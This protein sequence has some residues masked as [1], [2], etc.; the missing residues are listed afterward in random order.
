MDCGC[1]AGATD[2]IGPRSAGWP[3]PS[4]SRNRRGLAPGPPG[5]P[6]AP[7]SRHPGASSRGRNAVRCRPWG[8]RAGG[9]AGRGRRDLRGQEDDIDSLAVASR[10]RL[11][12][13]TDVE[14]LQVVPTVR[15]E[16]VNH[17][18][19]H[20]QALAGVLVQC[21]RPPATRRTLAPN[22]AASSRQGS[23]RASC[24]RPTS[25]RPTSR[26]RPRLLDKQIN[27]S[28]SLAVTQEPV[29]PPQHA[30][31]VGIAPIGAGLVGR[32]VDVRRLRGAC[33]FRA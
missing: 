12:V 10:A 21:I 26:D 8:G 3:A 22:R 33:S 4:P 30:E 1:P 31:K 27:K 17:G 13:D 14:D 24:P 7:S 28:K 15:A 18:R 11:G 32:Q 19:P 20:R 5:N 23:A 25:T 29:P 9:G 6:E 2:G 16:W